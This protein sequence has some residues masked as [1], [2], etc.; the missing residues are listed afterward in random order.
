MIATDPTDYIGLVIGG[1]VA[2][3]VASIPTVLSNRRARQERD[4]ERAERSKEEAAKK[5]LMAERDKLIA[6]I[7]KQVIPDNGTKLVEYVKRIDARL[8]TAQQEAAEA[9]LEA[10]EAKFNWKNHLA[11][12]HHDRRLVDEDFYERPE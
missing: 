4:E 2:I 1:A 9:R 12:Y 6:E 8:R 3:G 11:S 5:R 10:T 7:A